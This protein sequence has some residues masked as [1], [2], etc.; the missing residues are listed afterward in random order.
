MGKINTDAI[1]RNIDPL[2]LIRKL[3]SNVAALNEDFDFR[4]VKQKQPNGDSIKVLQANETVFFNLMTTLDDNIFKT[5][6]DRDI[7]LFASSLGEHGVFADLVKN[8]ELATY[9]NGMSEANKEK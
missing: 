3:F 9:F 4:T 6:R 2:K 8:P 5:S 7:K 1:N